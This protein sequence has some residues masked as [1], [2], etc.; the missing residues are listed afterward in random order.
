VIGR[1]FRLPVDIAR[2][3]VNTAST[4]VKIGADA[5]MVIPNAISKM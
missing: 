2:G 5:I 3:T 4:A 1:W